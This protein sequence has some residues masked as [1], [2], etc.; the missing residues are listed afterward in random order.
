MKKLFVALSRYNR[1]T[2]AVICEYLSSTSQD[3]LLLERESYYPSIVHSFLH[4]MKSDCKWSSRLSKL[5]PEGHLKTIDADTVNP[6]S[7][8]SIAAGHTA[9]PEIVALRKE[10]DDRIVRF[11]SALDAEQFERSVEIPFGQNNITR[12]LWELLLQWFN[13][14]TH[15][16]GQISLQ[17]ELIGQE[18][19]Y[20]AV[21]GKIEA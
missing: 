3:K 19:D 21:L 17:L 4:V 12:K 15:H 14:Q 2:N 13:H 6:I 16:R 10:I 7:T 20:S 8:E 18:N 1:N 5:D 9:I 11:I